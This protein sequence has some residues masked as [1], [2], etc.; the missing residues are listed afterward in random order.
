M[1]KKL[2]PLKVDNE[3]ATLIPPLQD[4]EQKM[5]TESIL[6]NGCEMP[7][8]VWNGIIV[9][10]HN[11]YRI[12]VENNIP[13]ATEEKEFE[14]KD[15]VKVWIIRNQLGRRNL[16]DFQRCELVLPLE[17][18][19][20]SEA[21]RARRDAIRNYRRGN[22][23]ET[24]QNSA[25]SNKETRDIL[26]EMAG[27]SHD[28]LTKAKKIIASADEETK[29]KLRQGKISIHKAYKEVRKQEEVNQETADD[30]KS[31]PKKELSSCL[32]KP[33]FEG[34]PVVVGNAVIPFEPVVR[35]QEPPADDCEVREDTE[36]QAEEFLDTMPLPETDAEQVK[37]VI[38]E[39][40]RDLQDAIE[41]M[42]YRS[43]EQILSLVRE[44]AKTAENIIM[45][46][47]EEETFHEKKKQ[48][49]K[50]T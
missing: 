45:K 49:K 11:R 46:H 48:K 34:I 30:H 21:E 42:D 47:F 25:A 40:L 20:K 14:S 32:D 29:D 5:L 27:V 41:N 12:C 19:L 17:E 37:E 22:T 10:G 16:Q 13:F 28:T 2:Y 1:E 50:T 7:L 24:P 3:L 8:V 33:I 4:V 26:S 43:A 44:A 15:A 6:A 39:F 38:A 23:V 31:A 18:L 36:E 35:D 9:D